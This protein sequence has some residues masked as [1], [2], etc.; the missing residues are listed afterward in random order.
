MVTHGDIITLSKKDA[1]VIVEKECQKRLHIS[2]KEFLKRRRLG[3]LPRS[4]AVSDIEM[5]LK[6]AKR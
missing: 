6:L 3:Q 5:M 2:T 4:E 1:A